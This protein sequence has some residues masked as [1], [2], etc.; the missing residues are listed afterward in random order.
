VIL[1]MG[2]DTMLSAD[3]VFSLKERNV[4]FLYE[5][6]RDLRPGMIFSIWLDNVESGLEGD[7]STEWDNFRRDLIRSGVQLLDRPNELKWMGGDKSRQLK[8]LN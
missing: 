6:S 5:A 3:L 1:G 8:V 2:K 4:H 7:L